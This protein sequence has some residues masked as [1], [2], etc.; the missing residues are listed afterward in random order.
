MKL[1]AIYS[2]TYVGFNAKNKD[3]YIFYYLED[4][5]LSYEFVAEAKYNT[6]KLLTLFVI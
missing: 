2:L 6:A 1:K 3:S 5:T 4:S